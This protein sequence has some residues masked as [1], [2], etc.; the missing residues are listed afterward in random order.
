MPNQRYVQGNRYEARA[1]EQLRTNGYLA[2]QTRGS[3]SPADIVAIKPDRIGCHVLL[4]QV[5]GG[6]STSITG[7]EWN[8]LYELAHAYGARPIVCERV[9]L[10]RAPIAL[11]WKQITGWHE[12]YSRDWPS[13]PFLM[14][15]VM[16]G[17]E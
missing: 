12:E 2:Y 6:L 11:R 7:N 10:E 4:V 3:K 1:A 13:R 9:S 8:A 5:K 14:D 17:G 15:E 16:H